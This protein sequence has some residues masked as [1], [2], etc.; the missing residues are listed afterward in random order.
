MIPDV[1]H[2]AVVIIFFYQKYGIYPK[3]VHLFKKGRKT[4]WHNLKE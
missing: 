1:L 4:Y 2:N 3:T